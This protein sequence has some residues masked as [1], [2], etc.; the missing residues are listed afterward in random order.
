MKEDGREVGMTEGGYVRGRKK[1]KKK[2]KKEVEREKKNIGV[3]S[4]RL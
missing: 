3:K 2:K 1:A 4:N